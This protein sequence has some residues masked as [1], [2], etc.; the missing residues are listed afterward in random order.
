MILFYSASSVD[1]D[2]DLGADLSEILVAE[3]LM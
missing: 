1:T 2:Y 3:K